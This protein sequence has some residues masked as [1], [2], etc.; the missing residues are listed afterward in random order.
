M[1][2]Y[3]EIILA[4]EHLV[5][6]VDKPNNASTEFLPNASKHVNFIILLVYK[7]IFSYR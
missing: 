7:F 5:Q 1:K 6:F 4:L 2:M 3:R